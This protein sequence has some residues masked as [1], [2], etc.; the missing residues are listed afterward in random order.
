MNNKNIFTFLYGISVIVLFWYMLHFILDTV[1]IPL[2]H[3]V[4]TVLVR[5]YIDGGLFKHSVCSMLRIFLS[6]LPAVITAVPL[7]MA[8]GLYPAA[9]RLLSPPAAVL[10]P[11]PKIAFL[12]VFMMLFGLGS[13]SK[14]MLIYS[15]IVFHIYFSIKDSIKR[16]PVN[17]FRHAEVLGIKSYFKQFIVFFPAV[18]PQF[19]TALRLALGIGFAVLFISENYAEKYG[20]GYFIMNSW[21]MADYQ[22]VYAGITALSL[23]AVLFYFITGLLEKLLCR[24]KNF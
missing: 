24:W 8:A 22:K 17:Y 13:I 16:L 12:P 2:P 14:I 4:F 10:F 7:G 11:L 20:L 6:L 19:F 1:L 15:V 9:D 18:M 5:L 21:I 23:C 3:K